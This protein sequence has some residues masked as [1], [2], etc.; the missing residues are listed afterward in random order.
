M[1]CNTDLLRKRGKAMWYKRVAAM[2]EA[3]VIEKRLSPTL[4]SHKWNQ[5][6]RIP[7]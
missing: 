1:G 3:V 6:T 7:V 2:K 4:D 5:S